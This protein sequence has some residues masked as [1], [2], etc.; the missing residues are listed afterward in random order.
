MEIDPYDIDLSKVESPTLRRLVEEVRRELDEERAI[1][2]PKYNR[3]HN[4]HNRSGG[5][6]RQHNRHNA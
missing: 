5:Y 1:L 3:Q 2:I 6:N 4:R